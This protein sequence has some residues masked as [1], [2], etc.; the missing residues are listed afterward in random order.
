LEIDMTAKK[1]NNV[2]VFGSGD[3]GMIFAHG[4]GCDQN[5]WR[6]LTP[7]FED[8]FR[9]IVFDLVGCGKSDLSAYDRRRYD[10][11][12]GHAQ[13]VVDTSTSWM[14]EKPFSS[15]TPSAL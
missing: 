3:T 12:N 15:A 7:H 4:Y 2:H 10:T 13:D 1:K 11:L 8:R 9:I 14:S 5:M 6:L